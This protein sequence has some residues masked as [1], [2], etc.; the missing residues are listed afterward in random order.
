[1]TYPRFPSKINPKT[2]LLQTTKF[3]DFIMKTKINKI[4]FIEFWNQRYNRGKKDKYNFG[5][6][7][8]NSEKIKPGEKYQSDLELI[9]YLIYPDSNMNLD[10]HF[11]NKITYK[12]ITYVPLC[13]FLCSRP[14]SI[15]LQYQHNNLTCITSWFSPNHP[16]KFCY[17]PP[18]PRP[19]NRWLLTSQQ[20][21][22]YI[23]VGVLTTK[24]SSQQIQTKT[25]QHQVFIRK[26]IYR[27]ITRK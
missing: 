10:T 1:M 21:W 27:R 14:Q 22:K 19:K 16:L 3:H 25:R 6:L 20:K 7:T 24:P 9:K 17:V 2:K 13:P 4:H 18:L 15:T 23:Q 12:R 11:A 26:I 5:L 8:V